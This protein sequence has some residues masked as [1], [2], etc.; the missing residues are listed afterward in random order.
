MNQTTFWL[1]QQ[2]SLS[3][4]L[5]CSG[6]SETYARGAQSAKSGPTV[7]NMK[8]MHLDKPD[9]CKIKREKGEKKE[10]HNLP[11]LFKTNRTLCKAELKYSNY[12]FL[13][14]MD[15]PMARNLEKHLDIQITAHHQPPAT[16]RD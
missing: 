6:K 9:D 4:D 7:G 1:Y 2:T 14:N 12:P 13:S 16:R 3:P 15:F 10:F 5:N 11:V 8:C